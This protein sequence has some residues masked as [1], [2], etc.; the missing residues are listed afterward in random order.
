MDENR[1]NNSPTNL[2][3]LCVNHHNEIHG[4]Y[5]NR[6]KKGKFQAKK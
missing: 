6:D 4:R 2:M 5:R 3:V 1:H